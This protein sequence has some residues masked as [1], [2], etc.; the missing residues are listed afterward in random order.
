MVEVRLQYSDGRYS[1]ARVLGSWQGK[2][3][4]FHVSDQVWAAYQAHL[5]QD[6]VFQAL[7]LGLERERDAA[8]EICT[9]DVE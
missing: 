9:T 1:M 3:Q 8:R 2:P 4:N 6:A 7:M 5:N